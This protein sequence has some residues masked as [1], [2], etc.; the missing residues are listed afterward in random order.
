MFFPSSDS[1]FLR[2]L[3]TLCAICA[4]TSMPCDAVVT[5]Y[6]LGGY[7]ISAGGGH[8]ASAGGCYAIDQTIGQP[9][10]SSTSGGHYAIVSGFLPGHVDNNS[11]FNGS[12]EVCS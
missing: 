1:R 10:A 2:S 3:R 4:V 11:I 9:F 7:V 5:S 6:S 12:F 8:S